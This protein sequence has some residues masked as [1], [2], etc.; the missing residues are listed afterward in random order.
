DRLEA[1]AR[2]K[3]PPTG[4]RGK[5]SGAK[6]RLRD[7]SGRIA[8]ACRPF[9]P[10]L[11][12][13]STRCCSCSVLNPLPWISEKCAKRSALPSSGAMKPKPLDSLNHLT[14]PVTRLLMLALHSLRV[15]EYTGAP[16][17][18]RQTDQEEQSG[19]RDALPGTGRLAGHAKMDDS[20]GMRGEAYRVRDRLSSERWTGAVRHF[21]PARRRA[22]RGS[23][24]PYCRWRRPRRIRPLRVRRSAARACRA[25]L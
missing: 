3:R 24:T 15:R 23:A 2:T 14:T 21:T 16:S 8:D 22:R 6:R 18:R 13:N 10:C 9:G 5:D 11:T 17:P 12:A 4:G 25:P 20:L 7:Y 1:V 19:I